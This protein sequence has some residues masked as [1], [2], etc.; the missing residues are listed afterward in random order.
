MYTQVADAKRLGDLAERTA[1]K[2][3]PT[4]RAVELRAGHL[5]V[6]FGVDQPR[7]LAK[8]IAV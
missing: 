5:G 2:L 4:D 3:Q 7:G 6:A 8:K 1:G